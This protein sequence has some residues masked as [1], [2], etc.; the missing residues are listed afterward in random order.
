MPIQSQSRDGATAG[1]QGKEWSATDDFQRFEFIPRGVNVI[2]ET[3][4]LPV[5]QIL[6]T[7][8]SFKR[9]FPGPSPANMAHQR[10]CLPGI[11]H[12]SCTNSNTPTMCQYQPGYF[13]WCIKC[14]MYRFHADKVH[15]YAWGPQT[16]EGSFEWKDVCTCD[17]EAPKYWDYHI[18][19]PFDFKRYSGEC[20]A[21]AE[22]D[23]MLDGVYPRW[24][25]RWTEAVPKPWAP[26]GVSW[27]KQTWD[28]VN[29]GPLPEIA[30]LPSDPDSTPRQFTN[31]QEHISPLSSL[32]NSTQTLRWNA[33]GTNQPTY[34][35]HFPAGS[36]L[37]QLTPATRYTTPVHSRREDDEMTDQEYNNRG[38]DDHTQ[39]TAS[40]SQ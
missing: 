19:H 39:F 7:M 38:S 28:P 12:Q 2:A 17:G 37:T 23:H 6:V 4:H 33:W 10:I 13:A 26:R 25:Q 32:S 8:C 22:A 21:E 29:H 24:Y 27:T 30:A 9:L 14:E 18:P 40:G 1:F 11:L 15:P 3:N 16:A 36:D 31:A 34:N 5:I 35:P 20:E